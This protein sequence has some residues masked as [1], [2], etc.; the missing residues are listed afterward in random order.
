MIDV[1]FRGHVGDI[2]RS[3]FQRSI[4]DSSL[5]SSDCLGRSIVEVVREIVSPDRR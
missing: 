5:M 2:W 1:G 3:R 4:G